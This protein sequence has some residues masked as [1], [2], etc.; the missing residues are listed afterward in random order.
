MR[1]IYCG[2]S[3]FQLLALIFHHRF[4][5]SFFIERKNIIYFLR[6]YFTFNYTF[7]FI[8]I[9][10]CIYINFL[11]SIL[12]Y[13]FIHIREREKEKRVSWRLT[14]I[15][16]TEWSFDR[17]SF[18][19]FQQWSRH[20]NSHDISYISSQNLCT[21]YILQKHSSNHSKLLSRERFSILPRW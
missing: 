15:N 13:I 20:F 4:L 7:L 1:T 14:T 11:F 10:W 21:R 2:L 5:C 12:Y 19:Q 17:F 18:V 16:E 9:L 8:F 3:H 6:N